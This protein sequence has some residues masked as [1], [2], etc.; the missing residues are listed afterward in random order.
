MGLAVFMF[1]PA[2]RKIGRQKVFRQPFFQCVPR[3]VGH[4]GTMQRPVKRIVP[5]PVDEFRRED[6][7]FALTGMV[8]GRPKW[9]ARRAGTSCGCK[10]QRFATYAF[11]TDAGTTR[12]P[13]CRLPAGKAVPDKDAPNTLPESLHRCAWLVLIPGCSPVRLPAEAAGWLLNTNGITAA[14]TH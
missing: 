8:C 11:A 6:P 14:L 13:A 1:Q 7:L 4:D 2:G 10:P 12:H 3:P 5:A 9:Q